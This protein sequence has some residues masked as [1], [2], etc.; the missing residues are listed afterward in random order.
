M[1]LLAFAFTIVFVWTGPTIDEDDSS[2][3]ITVVTYQSEVSFLFFPS[4]FT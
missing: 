1:R 3:L 4:R 2:G